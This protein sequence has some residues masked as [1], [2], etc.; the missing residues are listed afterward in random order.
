MKTILTKSLFFVF[1]AVSA[2]QAEPMVNVSSLNQKLQ[3][4]N[5]TWVAK[6]TWLSNLSKQE[7]KKMMGLRDAPPTDFE[8]VLPQTQA[9]EAFP[10]SIDWRNKD[11]RN[12]VTPILN[13]GTC[14]SCVAFAALGVMETQ[15]NIS[16]LLPNLN[17]RLSPQ[18]LFSCG[19]GAC[20]FGW[21]PVS[22]AMYLMKSGVT[23]EACMPYTSGA[24]GVD[25]ACQATCADIS[26][27]TYKISDYNTPT[28]YGQDLNAVKRALQKGPLVTTLAVYADF[29]SYAGGIYQHTSGDYVGGHAVSI[30]GYDDATQSFIIRN[31]WGEEWG[32]KGF[33]HVSYSDTSGIGSSTWAYDVPAMTGA[34][35]I[36]SP[37]D[38]TYVTGTVQFEA[39]S[40]FN[41]TD[42]VS[43]TIFSNNKAVWTSTC[44]NQNCV[45]S[46]D[47][48]TLPDGR[49]EIQA[50]ATNAHGNNLG[51]SSRQ[52]F[53]V[54]NQKPTL[55]L[56]FN[57]GTKLD[58]SKPLKGRVEFEIATQ[59]SGVPMS[60]LE[61]RFKDASG[62][63]SA[64]VSHVVLNQMKT[65]WRTTLVPN[66][67]YEIW[68][69]GR[70][71]SNTMD[72]ST[73]SQHYT[74]T[75][76]N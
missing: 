69:V 63:E 65:G 32:E 59:S 48:T 3:K 61:F 7:A 57:G 9:Q 30:V 37:R 47:S 75:V 73:E 1:F 70:V 60:S 55:S 2:V 68:M 67:T 13:Q 54:V 72:I 62:K 51:F 76:Q 6:E 45:A 66:G 40:T 5:A 22:A 23:D 10:V 56:S 14:G 36:L 18:H 50:L 26:Q 27:R 20:D 64:R 19:R 38:Y 11:G 17:L 31:S 43:F 58:L 35:S 28:T 15:M 8:F 25:V 16:S 44:Q 4:Q 42:G 24:T 21:Y 12:W 52:F 53:Y 74:V 33:G 41:S 39:A 71:K 34:I 29:L 49:Y 46:F